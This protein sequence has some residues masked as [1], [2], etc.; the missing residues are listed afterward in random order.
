M[1]SLNTNAGDKAEGK[2][3]QE[4]SVILSFEMKKGFY[5]YY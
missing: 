3:I 1:K 4:T 2:K 5:P